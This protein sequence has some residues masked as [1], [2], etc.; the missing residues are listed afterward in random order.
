MISLPCVKE[1]DEESMTEVM[2]ASDLNFEAMKPIDLN[3]EALKPGSNATVFS[4]F[5]WALVKG[6]METVEAQMTDDI[7]WGLMP[8]NK[9]LKGKDE[10]IPWLK[11]GYSSQKEPIAISNVATEDWGIFEYWNI[12]TVTEELVKFGNQQEWPWPKDPA[13]L[14]GRKYKV[15]Q[16]FVYHVNSK[17]KI[18]FMRQYLDAGGV[19]AQFK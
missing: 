13:G 10:V 6:D 15:A 9:I 3:T 12:G 19:W 5:L 8:Y 7:E 14:I 4:T 1:R 17:K 18:D 16:C 2:K 11:A